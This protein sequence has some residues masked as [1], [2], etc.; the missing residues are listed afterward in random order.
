MHYLPLDDSRLS[1]RRLRVSISTFVSNSSAT[2]RP[3][4]N[5]K[6]TENLIE[7]ILWR[8][9]I[10]IM[11]ADRSLVSLKCSRKKCFYRPQTKLREGNVFTPVCQSILFTG[12]QLH[13][14]GACVMGGVHGRGIHGRRYR[15]GRHGRE[16]CVVVGYV[17]AGDTATEAGGMHSTGMHSWYCFEYFFTTHTM[18]RWEF[19]M[20]FM[21]RYLSF[22]TWAVYG[23]IFD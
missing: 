9:L 22:V 4:T 14:R 19:S 20:C 7:T 18:I 3:N 2:T 6:I 21:Y 8:R 15:H 11:F 5:A 17:C 16:A 10:V 13:G 23:N 12:G 1:T